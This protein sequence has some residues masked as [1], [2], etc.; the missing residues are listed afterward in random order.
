MDPAAPPSPVHNSGAQHKWAVEDISVLT[1]LL[2]TPRRPRTSLTRQVQ[3]LEREL[4]GVE[5]QRAAKAVARA[6][7]RWAPSAATIKLFRHLQRL[8]RV[9]Q[10]LAAEN[11]QLR[12]VLEARQH[13]SVVADPKQPSRP[14]GEEAMPQ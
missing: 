13:W 7:G 8:Q 11:Q 14:D 10:A 2:H 3:L 5:E 1:Q 9:A 4:D 6:G 12:T